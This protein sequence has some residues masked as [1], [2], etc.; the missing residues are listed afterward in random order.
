MIKSIQTTSVLNKLKKRDDWFLVDYSLNPYSGCSFNCQYCYIRG[1]KYGLNMAKN[2]AV[3]INAPELLEKQL[4]RRTEKGEYGIIA[5]SSATDPYLPIEKDLRMTR[6]LLEIILKYKFPVEIVTKSP[7]VLEDLDLLER[8]DHSVILPNDLKKKLK[9]GV[10]ISFSFSNMDVKLSKIFEP[11]APIPQERLKAMKEC[12][13]K[14]LLVGANLMPILPFITDQ[15]E[16]LE[17]MI[18]TLKEYCADYVLVGGLTLFG[19]SPADCKTLY[20]QA[21]EKYFPELLKP[22]KS[23]FRIFFSPPKDYQTKLEKTAR[24][25]CEKYNL[26]YGI[27]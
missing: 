14:G 23:L 18:R 27:L 26:R 9:H 2:L 13:R 22:T 12:K 7:L 3:K 6:K 25:F 15:E 1:S 11:G 4:K 16:Y 17:K 21:L 8:I 10:I 24:E 20:Y 19:K 5:L